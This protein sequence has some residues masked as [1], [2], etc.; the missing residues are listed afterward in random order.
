[1]GVIALDKR[2]RV[3]VAIRGG[4]MPHAWLVEGARRI[5]ARMHLA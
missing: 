3:G 2:A 1:V 5:V 4:A